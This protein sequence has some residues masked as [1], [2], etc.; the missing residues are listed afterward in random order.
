MKVVAVSEFLPAV[1]RLINIP[2]VPLLEDAIV[3]S[4]RTF[5]RESKIVFI[6]RSFDS[7]LTEQHISV[8]ESSSDNRLSGLNIK[9]S[10]LERITAQ[11][12]NGEV[13]D[14]EPEVNY[15]QL[16]RD[17]LTF[18]TAHSNVTIISTVEPTNGATKL[19]Q[20]LYED[21]L[22]AIAH[23]AV[24]ILY[25]QPDKD[26]F[27]PDMAGYYERLFVEG[28]RESARFRLDASPQI[29][30]PVKRARNREFF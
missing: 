22:R 7:V 24:A 26:W 3:E 29:T 2:F 21:Y 6:S 23:G 14:L 15:H 25:A 9:A 1:R 10:N 4:A 20:V 18:I 5:C 8:V 19:P 30:R 16:S 17:R 13:L 12:T 28:Y 11:T 27:N